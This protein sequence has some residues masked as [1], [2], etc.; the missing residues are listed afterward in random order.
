MALV[1]VVWVGAIG[2][3]VAVQLQAAGHHA[4]KLCTRQPMHGRKLHMP[5]GVASVGAT[6]VIDPALAEAADCAARGT[7]P[8]GGLV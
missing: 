1:A 5:D 4:I 8:S 3:V 6:N 7:A 2:G